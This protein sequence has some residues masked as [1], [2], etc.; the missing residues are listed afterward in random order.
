MHQEKTGKDPEPLSLTKILEGTGLLSPS[1][2]YS[3]YFTV[4]FQTEA[5]FNAQIVWLKKMLPQ[6]I[7]LLIEK[8]GVHLAIGNP[9][10]APLT[11]GFG[12]I[13]SG[14]TEYHRAK[15]VAHLR[16]NGELNREAIKYPPTR[17]MLDGQIKKLLYEEIRTKFPPPFNY[18]NPNFAAS[19][20][21]SFYVR[22]RDYTTLWEESEVRI[23]NDSRFY[24]KLNN[25]LAG[26]GFET[27]SY[28]APEK[29]YNILKFI[30]KIKKEIICRDYYDFENQ[31]QEFFIE[32]LSRNALLRT[33]EHQE[34]EN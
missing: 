15:I 33:E 22:P 32:N 9:N 16:I 10:N 30:V 34:E 5:V 7:G 25:F 11:E 23:F 19:V 28:S 1:Q 27:L 20:H 12:L 4:T 13:D 26:K 8:A 3:T 14:K 18:N 2:N 6:W 21:C 29:T 31:L 24:D 17:R